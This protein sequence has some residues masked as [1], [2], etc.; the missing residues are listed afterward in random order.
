MN[1]KPELLSSIFIL[2]LLFN[3]VILNRPVQSGLS[4]VQSEAL[5]G[6]STSK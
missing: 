2:R 1:I 5:N 4:K 6:Y 3:V